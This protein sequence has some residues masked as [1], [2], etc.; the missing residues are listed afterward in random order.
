MISDLQF[1]AL[2]FRATLAGRSVQNKA[3]SGG[4]FTSEK[5]S[6]SSS[7]VEAKSVV[8]QDLQGKY[9]L[10]SEASRITSPREEEAKSS[11]EN[12]AERHALPSSALVD[13]MIKRAKISSFGTSDLSL[14]SLPM[15]TILLVL[16]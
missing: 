8:V 5:Q 1:R 6:V 4:H 10:A 13:K 12:S 15:S 11:R 9:S 16:I 14:N 3:D 7:L 2:N